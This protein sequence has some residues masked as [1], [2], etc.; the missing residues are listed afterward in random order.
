MI[1]DY[2]ICIYLEFFCED[3]FNMYW[4]SNDMVQ[5]LYWSRRQKMPLNNW[6]CNL[7]ITIYI[8]C[9]LISCL[10]YIKFVV[11]ISLIFIFDSLIHWLQSSSTMTLIMY[12]AKI[13]FFP[14]VN[15]NL[16]ALYVCVCYFLCLFRIQFLLAY[17]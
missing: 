9:L 16:V 12:L 11:A 6:K 13:S 15:R 1:F 8:F 2:L 17:L 5:L 14:D 10:F 4:R 7:P 3:T